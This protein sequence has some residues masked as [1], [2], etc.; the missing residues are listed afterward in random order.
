MVKIRKLI[1]RQIMC[2]LYCW[3]EAALDFMDRHNTKIQAILHPVSMATLVSVIGFLLV[4]DMLYALPD[5]TDPDGLWYKINLF[6][7]IFVVYSIFSNLW[8]CFWTDTSVQALPEHRLRP[9]PEE[10]HLW[11][12][13]ASCEIM[14]PP[15]AWHCRLCKTCCLKRDHHCTFSA[16]CIGHRNQ[17]YF[18]VFLFYGTL[19]S[20]QSLV[21]NCIYVWTTGAFVVADPFLILSFGQPRTDPSM[22][23]KIITSMVL[24]LNVVAAI[25]ASGMFIT[26]V[27]MVYRNSTCFMMSDRTYDLGPMNNFRQVLGKRGFWTLLSSHINSP[28]PNDGTEWQMTKHTDV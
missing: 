26:Q 18:L 16:N 3:E 19:G 5:L 12:Y 11:H 25:A 28:L 20:F 7:S 23:W 24:K 22:G 17:R 15:R 1:L 13:C 10:A 14:V 8:I 2:I 4:Y 6:W 21:Y 27:L 9:P